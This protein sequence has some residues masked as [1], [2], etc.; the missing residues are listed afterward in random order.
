MIDEDDIM[1]WGRWSSE[2]YKVYARKSKMTR[3]IIFNKIRT[4]ISA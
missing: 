1:V 4:I 3:K 2:A